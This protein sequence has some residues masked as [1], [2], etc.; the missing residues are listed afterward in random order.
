VRILYAFDY[1]RRAIL[2]LGGD[3][4]GQW[5]DWYDR[6]V[7]KADTLLFRHVEQ[8]RGADAEAEARPT[9]QSKARKEETLMGI[10]ETR[11]KLMADPAAATR[12][13]GYLD[14]NHKAVALADLR[15]GRVT[16]AELAA[17][18]GVSQ[19][20]V[21]AIEHSADVQVSTL[22]AYL[23]KLGYDL[24]LCA[25]SATGERIPLKLG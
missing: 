8:A 3:E 17:V 16:Q 22:S 7:P 5:T 2:L 19:R 24:E 13:L 15:E 23:E 12:I 25:R 4:A 1:R 18:L 6:N 11:K 21:S 20:R 10:T 9:A 14:D